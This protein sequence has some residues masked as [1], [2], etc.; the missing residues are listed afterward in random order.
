MSA[1]IP[2]IV[3]IAIPARDEEVLIA[4]CLHA[5]A[6]ASAHPSLAQV[7]VY[8]LVVLDSCTDGTK[9]ICLAHGVP[10]VEVAF[11][12]VGLARGVGLA[13]LSVMAAVRVGTNGLDHRRLWLATTDADTA[14]AYDWLAE[15]VRL[16]RAGA[17]AVFGV[18]DVDDWSA[19]PVGT[20]AHFRALYTGTAR[21]DSAAHRHIHGANL[22]VRLDAYLRV[23]GMPA[24]AVG[25]DQ[26]LA[27]RLAAEPGLRIVRST[28]VRATT[29]GRLTSRTHGGF[30]DLLVSLGSSRQY[31][32]ARF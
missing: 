25:E 17:D 23:G 10:T 28:A 20:R 9:A 3:G 2:D 24:L 16:A 19:H 6:V 7:D 29:S 21:T 1:A 31:G 27:A 30:A 18:I 32:G 4:D 11:S 13:A 26:A 5:L 14:V 22:G 12:N 8:P 15:Q